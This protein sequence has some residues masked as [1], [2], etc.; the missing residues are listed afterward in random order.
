MK[1]NPL[2][3]P[4]R[5]APTAILALTLLAAQNAGYDGA[6]AEG[7]LDTQIGHA[8]PV[9]A[10]HGMVVAQEAIAAD[11]GADILRKG[12]NAVDAAVATAFALAVT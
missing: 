2:R 10:E 5:F 8:Q 6:R 7:R 12:G 9:T 3:S 1:I 4:L 11:I